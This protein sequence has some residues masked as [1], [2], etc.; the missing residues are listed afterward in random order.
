MSRKVAVTFEV[1]IPALAADTS[2]QLIAHERAVA[3]AEVLIMQLLPRLAAE[4]GLEQAHLAG[5]LLVELG[6]VVGLSHA[7]TAAIDALA[8]ATERMRTGLAGK[9]ARQAP[10]LP[11]PTV[12][13]PTTLQ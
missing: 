12:P 9:E 7:P 6:Y 3:L 2:A 11:A 13:A 1:E 8:A 4:A 10:V 5:R